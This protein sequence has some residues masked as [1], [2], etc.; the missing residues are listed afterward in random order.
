MC[1]TEKAVGDYVL[2]C[3]WLPP[4]KEL[5]VVL[6]EYYH[7]SYMPLFYATCVNFL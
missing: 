3:H 1:V 4:E 7:V 6:K 5:W 2:N